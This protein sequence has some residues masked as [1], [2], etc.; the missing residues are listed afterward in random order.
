MTLTTIE[1]IGIGVAVGA[2]AETG[3]LLLDLWR[4]RNPLFRVLNVLVVFG[5]VMGAVATLTPTLG[6]AAVF[7]IAVAIGLAY[8]AANLAWLDW[9]RFPD[10]RLGPI[11]GDAAC[12]TAIAVAWGATPLVITTVAAAL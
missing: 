12:A 1:A 10:D 8:E 5:V 6:V 3:A 4:Y 7:G 11:R 2:V 9:W